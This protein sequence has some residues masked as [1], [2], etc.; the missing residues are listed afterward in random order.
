MELTSSQLLALPQAK[1]WDALNDPAVLKACIPGCETVDKQSDTQYEVAIMAAVGPVKARFKGKMELADLDPPRGY[2]IKFDGQGGAAGFGKGEARVTLEP[3]GTGTRLSYTAKAQIGGKLA[4]VGSRLV[5]GV[6]RK[7]ADE[8]FVRFAQTV[9]PPE[10]AFS[11]AGGTASAAGDAGPAPV[12]SAPPPS[13]GRPPIPSW[14]WL[15]A[16]AIAAALVVLWRH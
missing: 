16:A 9:A 12:G 11:P 6:A 13:A 2:T 10:A 3:E 8:F 1:V 14:V 4:Q 7:M 15:A 5:D